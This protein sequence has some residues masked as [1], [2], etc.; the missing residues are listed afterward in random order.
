MLRWILTAPLLVLVI[1]FAL[2]NRDPVTFRLWPL[3]LSWTAPLSVAVLAVA[4][5][6]FLVGAL[7]AWGAALPARRR[8][9]QMA[10]VSRVLEAELS[11]YRAREAREVAPRPAAAGR[12]SSGT[13][14]VALRRDAA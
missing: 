14:V 3:D 8:A 2:S 10:E 13:S 1:L 6:A 7:I 12:A 11:E 4:A 9:S 5:A